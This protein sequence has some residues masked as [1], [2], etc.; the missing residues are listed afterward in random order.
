[1]GENKFEPCQR[2]CLD[3][4][5]TIRVIKKKEYDKRGTVIRPS[6]I[7]RIIV[8]WDGNKTVSHTWERDLKEV[9]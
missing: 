3:L 2:V 6:F 8:L 1:M 7:G 4:S 5:H 9:K